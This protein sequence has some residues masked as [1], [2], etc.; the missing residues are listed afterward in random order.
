M[1]AARCCSPA[2][3]ARGRG[4]RASAAAWRSAMPAPSAPASS[5][6]P[7]TRART[8]AFLAALRRWAGP[9]HPLGR[10]GGAR[11]WCSTS[12]AAPI[13]SAARPGSSAQ[14]EAE[15]ADFGLT[16]PARPRRHPRRRLGGGALRRRRHLARAMPATPSTRRRAP[17]ARGRR[18]GAGSAAARRRRPARC[19]R[20]RLHRAAG[21]DHRP[22]RPAAGGGAPARRRPRSRRC[23]RSACAGSPTWRRCRGRSSPGGSGRR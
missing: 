23:R 8:A 4:G 13:S 10:R 3:T 15:A 9:L 16:P 19:R 11:R 1:R 5:P 2:S 14:V 17:P 7:R 22:Y 18:S 20:G 6:G 21:R 12:P